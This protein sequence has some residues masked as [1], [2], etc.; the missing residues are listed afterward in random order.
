MSLE[1]GAL[2]DTDTTKVAACDPLAMIFFRSLELANR[3]L[4]H[5]PPEQHVRK[6]QRRKRTWA[7]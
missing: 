7:G 4:R 3:D 6:R 2:Y 1:N 5:Q